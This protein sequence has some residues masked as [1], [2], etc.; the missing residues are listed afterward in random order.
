MLLGLEPPV[1]DP[2]LLLDAALIAARVLALDLAHDA[3]V[4]M[5]VF[6]IDIIE[7][8]H[9]LDDVGIGV[10]GSHMFLRR[11]AFGKDG[12]AYAKLTA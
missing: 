10:N 12:R 9:R 2:E 8:R 5:A 7:R 3:R 11:S 1:D 4:E 6:R